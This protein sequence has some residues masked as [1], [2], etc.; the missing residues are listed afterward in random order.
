ME[1]AAFLS[2][3]VVSVFSLL[4]PE[5]TSGEGPMAEISRQCAPSVVTIMALNENGEPLCSGTGFFLDTQGHVATNHHVLAGAFTAIAKTA[6]QRTGAVLEVVKDDPDLDLVVA[7]TTLR[8]TP[9]VALG[10]SDG[11]FPGQPVFGLANPLGFPATLFKGKVIAVRQAGDMEFIQMTVPVLPGCS[12]E[13]IFDVFGNV[14]GIATA[15][16]DSG[17]DLNFALPVKYLNALKPVRQEISALPDVATRFEAEFRDHILV[18]VVVTHHPGAAPSRTEKRRTPDEPLI[19]SESRIPLRKKGVE[20]GMVYF[21]NGKRLLCDKAW[22]RGETIF[23]VI[24]GKNFA[25]GYDESQIDINRSF[26]L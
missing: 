24:H 2:A 6:D 5:Q 26:I 21:K 8:D 13:P 10:D 4:C 22:K 9:P 15:F 25:V 1:K 17:E 20:P 18:G 16:V 23:L 19:F 7:R 11:V 14:I 12:G 3:L